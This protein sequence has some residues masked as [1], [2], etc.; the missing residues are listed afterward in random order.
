MTQRPGKKASRLNMLG[1]QQDGM[2]IFHVNPT[3]RA[4]PD[5]NGLKNNF[6]KCFCIGLE[7]NKKL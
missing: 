1:S 5:R 7:E 2:Y 3:R 4:V 6:Q